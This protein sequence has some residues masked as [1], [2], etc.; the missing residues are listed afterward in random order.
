MDWIWAEGMVG[1]DEGEVEAMGLGFRFK[2]GIEMELGFRVLG[3]GFKWDLK[4]D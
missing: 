3:F 4:W 2:I 1:Q